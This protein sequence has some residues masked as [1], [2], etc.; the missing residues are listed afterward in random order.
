MADQVRILF[1]GLEEFRGRVS[2]LGR[3]LR[4][5]KMRSI[6]ESAKN[7]GLAM[8]RKEVP[9]KTFLL[10]S[11]IFGEVRDFGT[12]NPKVILG[13][14]KSVYARFVEEKT[15]AHD[16]MPR[17]KKWLYWQT[18]GPR[19]EKIPWARGVVGPQGYEVWK[20][21]VRHPGTKAQPFIGPAMQAIRPRIILAIH[22]A[23][24]RGM[25][26]SK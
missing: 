8:A 4:T 14:R 19:G 20:K 23:I 12:D 6:L 5:P 3:L 11:Q 15:K 17:R 9:K 16:I 25:E 24:T 1:I 18:N 21:R 13:T 10:Y 26:R 2:E 22:N 7:T